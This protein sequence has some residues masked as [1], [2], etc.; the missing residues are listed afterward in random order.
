MGLCPYIFSP[1]LQLR[2]TISNCFKNSYPCVISNTNNKFRR[3]KLHKIQWYLIE[4]SLFYTFIKSY[5][6]RC[7]LCMDCGN[8]AQITKR[9]RLFDIYVYVW[10]FHKLEPFIMHRLSSLNVSIFA[11]IHFPVILIEKLHF[12]KL[13]EKNCV[14]FVGRSSDKRKVESKNF[15]ISVFGC[16]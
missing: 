16:V 7:F 2:N 3:F 15:S 8:F 14:K 1:L 12:V 4:I 9:K 13:I 10:N 5:W 11:C 6:F